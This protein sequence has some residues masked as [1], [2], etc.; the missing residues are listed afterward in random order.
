MTNQITVRLNSGVHLPARRVNRTN[1][2]P[3]I[4]S[5][6]PK[7]H[8]QT[9][10]KSGVVEA[11]RACCKFGLVEVHVPRGE[12]HASEVDPGPQEVRAGLQVLARVDDS[13][14]TRATDQSA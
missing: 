11:D 12:D 2:A 7:Y 5:V 8:A 9:P 1:A 6:Q 3:D 14:K 13:V 10:S 4:P